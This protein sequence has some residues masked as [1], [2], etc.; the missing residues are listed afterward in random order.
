MLEERSLDGVGLATTHSV[1]VGTHD[2]E[3][4]S[5][6]VSLEYSAP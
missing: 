3:C 4:E 2:V 1:P 6:V 5:R